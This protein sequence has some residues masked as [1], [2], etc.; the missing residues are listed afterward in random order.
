MVCLQIDE[1]GKKPFR[2]G[3]R[4]EISGFAHEK[5]EL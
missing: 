5:G 2:A 4:R 1:V 3:R